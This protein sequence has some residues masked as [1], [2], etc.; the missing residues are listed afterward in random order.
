MLK[1]FKE[2]IKKSLNKIVNYSKKVQPRKQVIFPN[3]YF[4]L[5]IPSVL[6][7]TKV[8]QFKVPLEMSKPQIKEYLEN[9]Y[10]LQIE[11]VRTLI[12]IGKVKRNRKT[13]RLVKRPSYKKAYVFLKDYI[14]LNWNEDVKRTIM[15]YYNKKLG[16]KFK[17]ED[18][19]K[20]L[21]E[22]QKQQQEQKQ[23]TNN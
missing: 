2:N 5:L 7:K 22:F 19:A 20:K 18:E 3:R 8:A 6:E 15:R 14:E 21:R 1:F 4:K 17:M 16:K 23:N 9:Y 12:Q 13:N 11:Q 10:G